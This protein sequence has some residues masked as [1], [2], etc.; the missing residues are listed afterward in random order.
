[1]TV[2]GFYVYL[3]I[4]N[5]VQPGIQ[6]IGE[7]KGFSNSD[8]LRNI[9][10][11][12]PGV[13]FV[14]VDCGLIISDEGD[15]LFNADTALDIVFGLDRYFVIV[16]GAFIIGGGNEYIERINGGDDGRM[17]SLYHQIYTVRQTVLREV[18]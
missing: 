12:D 15:I 17:L 8:I 13:V 3:Y 9:G 14:G 16:S 2:S 7:D 1:M 4:S 5:V 10:S 6:R 11:D 18:Q